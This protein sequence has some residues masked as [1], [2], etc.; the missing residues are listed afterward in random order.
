M[1]TLQALVTRVGNALALLRLVH[2]G[3]INQCCQ[4]ASNYAHLAQSLSPDSQSPQLRTL[5]SQY[6]DLQS[7]VRDRLSNK[8]EYYHLIQEALRQAITPE[9]AGPL[10]LFY[11]VLPAL[12]VS[13]IQH[14][15]ASTDAKSN[16][17]F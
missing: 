14:V 8:S 2:T 9:I 12:Q 17:H 3:H 11:L 13:H 6:Q 7:E 16:K 5:L 1:L 15:L 4:M 10:G